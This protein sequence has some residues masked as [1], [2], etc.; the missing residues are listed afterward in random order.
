MP[1]SRRV[2]TSREHAMSALGATGAAR[3]SRQIQLQLQRRTLLGLGLGLRRRRALPW[4]AGL[5]QRRATVVDS[6]MMGAT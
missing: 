4:A 6:L 2:V 5:Q 1:A 3:R